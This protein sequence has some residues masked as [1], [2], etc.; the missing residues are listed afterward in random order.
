MVCGAVLDGTGCD[1]SHPRF[2]QRAD[3]LQ[4]DLS[5]RDGLFDFVTFQS[6]QIYFESASWWFYL[7]DGYFRLAGGDADFLISRSALDIQPLTCIG[8]GG[9]FDGSIGARAF[10]TGIFRLG[11]SPTHDLVPTPLSAWIHVRTG[12]VAPQ[13]GGKEDLQQNPSGNPCWVIYRLTISD[14]CKEASFYYRSER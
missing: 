3:I 7:L 5:C 12:K 13:L 11:I 9:V 1:I 14:S 2:F 4:M 10:A 6:Q 8:K